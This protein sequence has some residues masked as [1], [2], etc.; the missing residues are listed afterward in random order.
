MSI[1][2]QT[3]IGPYV[4]CAVGVE[5]SVEQIRACTNPACPDHKHH[6]SSAF[7]HL[8]GSPVGDV[9]Y[10]T[11]KDAV[12]D[13]AVREEISDRLATA[14]GDGY[15]KWGRENHAHIWLPNVTVPWRDCHLEERADFVLVEILPGQREDELAQFRSWFANELKVLRQHYGATHVLIHWGIV[16]D[17]N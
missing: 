10:R 3:Y 2:Y 9:P 1:S 6:V 4:R 16:Q 7:C 13:W 15:S 14:S 5:E 11:V 12:D 8:C 17:Y